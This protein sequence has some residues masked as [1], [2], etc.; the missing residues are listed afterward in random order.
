MLA[1]AQKLGGRITRPAQDAGW[2]GYHGHFA[3]LGGFFWE[4]LRIPPSLS[5]KTAIS[6]YRTSSLPL[7]LKMAKPTHSRC[8][9]GFLRYNEYSLSF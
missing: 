7:L 6:R 8:L 4:I 3:D 2:G 5:R 9:P 1:Q